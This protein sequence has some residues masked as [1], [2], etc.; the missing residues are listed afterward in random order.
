MNRLPVLLVLFLAA[1]PGP[2]IGNPC[3]LATPDDG[4]ASATATGTVTTINPGAPECASRLCLMPGAEKPT[5]TGALC[6]A[7]CVSA[8]D[9][10]NAQAS[11]ATG[12]RLC[13]SGFA[14]MV[15][16]TVGDFC[17]RKL[18]VCKDFVAVPPS[19]PETPLA[20]LPGADRA[21]KPGP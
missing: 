16:T 3:N 6:T 14:C 8:D 1:C 7:E 19:G 12:D 2:R 13:R 10:A 20:C 17:C 4:G 21:C 11:G 18:C 15:M 5:N 9:C